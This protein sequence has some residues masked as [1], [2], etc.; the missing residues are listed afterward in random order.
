MI[1]AVVDNGSS[2]LNRNQDER[3]FP[4]RPRDL[5]PVGANSRLHFL[6]PSMVRFPSLILPQHLLPRANHRRNTWCSL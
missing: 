3:N 2:Y 4:S 6:H 1:F 5:P